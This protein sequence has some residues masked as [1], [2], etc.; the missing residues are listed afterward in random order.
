MVFGIFEE[1]PFLFKALATRIGL[2]VLSHA[3]AQ[4][5]SL[6]FLVLITYRGVPKSSPLFRDPV[7]KPS[8]EPWLPLQLKSLGLLIFSKK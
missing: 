6:F 3:V 7:P 1:V 2:V 5:V 8:I 4:L